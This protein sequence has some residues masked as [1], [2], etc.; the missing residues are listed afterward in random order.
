MN[1]TNQQNPQTQYTTQLKKD[2]LKSIE[3]ISVQVSS[4]W[5]KVQVPNPD[6]PL[7]RENISNHLEQLARAVKVEANNYSENPT[8]D[9]SYDLLDNWIYMADKSTEFTDILIDI[10]RMVDNAICELVFING[11]FCVQECQDI[12]RFQQSVI[13]CHDALLYNLQSPLS[14]LKDL[15][16]TA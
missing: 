13:K 4:L 14:E 15:D 2:I 1:S 7:T 10:K 8:D 5:L 6:E 16:F 9:D 11:F 12:D 3:N